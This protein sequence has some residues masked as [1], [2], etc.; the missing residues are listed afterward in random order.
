MLSGAESAK[1]TAYREHTHVWV[2]VYVCMIIISPYRLRHWLRLNDDKRLYYPMQGS[3]GQLNLQL[4][5]SK[6]TPTCEYVCMCATLRA[7]VCLFCYIHNVKKQ[8]DCAGK[9]V[10]ALCVRLGVFGFITILC[11]SA[12]L[13]GPLV[14]NRSGAQIT[15][16]SLKRKQNG[17]SIRSCFRNRKT[18]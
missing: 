12:P 2:C 11:N 10:C 6:S 17:I 14:A 13:T 9:W 5:V 16:S 8:H 1:A 7:C 15:D 3:V 4:S 18:G